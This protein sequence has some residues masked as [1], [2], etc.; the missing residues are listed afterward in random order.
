MTRPTR[1]LALLLLAL[2]TGV[3]A[4]Q[5][6]DPSA[7]RPPIAKR[8][9]HR[10]TAHGD[11]R[12]DEYYW[13][14]DKKSPAVRVHLEAENAYTKAAM[15]PTEPLQ[16]RLY[17]EMLG[18][19]K[20]TDLTVPH[21]DRGF[22]YYRRTEE[23]KQY[24]VYCR[25]TGTLQAPEEVL[26]DANALARGE[27]FF[28]VRGPV[29]SDDGNLLAFATDTTGFREYQLSVKDLRTGKLVETR[30]AQVTDFEWAADNRT[31]F[32]VTEDDA[33]RPHRL[34][35]HSLGRPKAEDVLVFEE[36]DG[37]FWLGLSRSRDGKY[38]FHLSESYTSA[39]Q[40]FLPTDTP[41]GAWKVILPREANHEYR[42]AH[43]DGR[44]YLRT[45][46]G[47][48]TN[49]KVV[50]CPVEK[51]APAHWRDLVPYDPA[52]MVTG[53]DVFRDH[54]VLSERVKGLPALR[55]LDLRSN[56]A[57]RI[58]F[59]EP[60]YDVELRA[61]PEFAT[62]AVQLTYTS[63]V[64][65]PA[66][67]EYHL[68][69]RK[70]VLLKQK[71][72]L[73][74]YDPAR[75]VSERLHATAADG[76]KVPLSLVY[77]KGVKKDGTAPLLLYGYGAYGSTLPLAFDSNRVSLLDRGIICALAHVRGGGEMGRAWYDGGKVRNR[78]KSFTDF[79]ACADHLVWEK[80]AARNRLV[81]QG[82]SAGGLLMAV[83]LS[84]RPDLCTAAVL[85]VPFVDAVT[86]MLDP[87]LPLVTQEYQEWGNPNEKGDYD[88][89]K[90]YC[91]YTNMR[92]G[93]YPSM[94][95]TTSLND[96]Q[97]MYWEPA[98]YVAR[99]R[100]MKRDNTPLLFRCDMAAG[101]G[102][103]SGRY[104]ALREDAFVMAFVLDRMG[105]RK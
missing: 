96:S 91:P 7:A 87:T 29:V 68:D 82:R 61:N 86:S 52:V 22:W 92:P 76:T 39:E 16:R 75:Y 24:P 8:V 67:Y 43:R 81:I 45:N 93:A 74:G 30:L 72:V 42:A 49:F 95:V 100:T 19:I 89:L 84:L 56:Q 15:K 63:L 55:V 59:P 98:K 58:D 41:A 38:L 80:Y 99:L 11:T 101:H 40:W 105:I 14:R 20:Q 104:D 103:A 65:P 54:A 17:D 5:R 90:S 53:V 28:D 48:A 102:G 10:L 97:V 47:G 2:V 9:P 69:T 50:T 4:A 44:F 13:M 21:R 51:T 3:L 57:Y 79:I 71:E 1:T 66:V 62:D 83:A 37:L 64:T 94:L 23:G 35:R 31:L 6:L 27:K 25:K 60:T 12:T 33:K 46:R 18:R 88:Y 36:K 73:G 26:L 34:W 77:R 78:M 32:Y 70:R 85:E